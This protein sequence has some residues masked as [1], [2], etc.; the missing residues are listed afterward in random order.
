MTQ[1]DF[2]LNLPCNSEKLFY[3]LTDFEN[4]NNYIPNQLQSVKVISKEN[5]KIITEE[6]IRSVSILKTEFEQKS[7]HIIKKNSLESEIISGPAKGTTI[8]SIIQKS[9]SGTIVF[10]KINLKLELKYIIF[11]PLIKK[12]YKQMLTGILY[13]MNRDIENT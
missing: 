11:T 13:K 8:E 1:L 12:I 4:F 5:D 2:S 7:Y 3:T 10:V 6:K 9:D